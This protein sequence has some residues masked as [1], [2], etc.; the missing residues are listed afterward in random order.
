MSR[1]EERIKRKPISIINWILTILLSVIPGVNIIG[2]I[3]MIIFAKNRSKKNF[4]IASLILIVL[5][6]VLFVAAFLVFGDQIVEFA[7]GLNA[8]E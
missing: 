1:S 2:F 8:A 7:K 3:A 4:A 6:A 5:L